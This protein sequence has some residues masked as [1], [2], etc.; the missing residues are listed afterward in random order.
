MDGAVPA[1][2]LLLPFGFIGLGLAFLLL[3]A[4]LLVGTREAQRRTYRWAV[5]L[6]VACL[7]LFGLSAAA[8]RT[9]I[10]ESPFYVSLGLL[11][12]GI[13]LSVVLWLREKPSA[14]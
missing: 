8:A 2:A 4:T 13:L 5:G 11:L 7:P 9:G 10:G 6:T 14:I 1:L 3:T 12:W